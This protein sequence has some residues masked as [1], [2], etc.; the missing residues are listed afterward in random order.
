MKCGSIGFCRTLLFEDASLALQFGFARDHRVEELDLG[1]EQ[2][3]RFELESHPVPDVVDELFEAQELDSAQGAP[4]APVN[5][6]LHLARFVQI[7]AET[8]V[9]GLL[10]ARPP[11]RLRHRHIV[12]LD[13][14][15]DLVT[16]LVLDAIRFGRTSTC[17]T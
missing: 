10:R 17:H 16:R 1:K 3:L 8:L 5:V 14:G 4:V 11:V 9:P 15:H 12:Q 6:D 7:D 2:P 13:D